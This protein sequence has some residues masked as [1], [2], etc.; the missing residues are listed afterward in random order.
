MNLVQE[1]TGNALLMI[2]KLEIHQ[3]Q[4]MVFIMSPQKYVLMKLYQKMAVVL[5]YKTMI[6]HAEKMKAKEGEAGAAHVKL[7]AAPKGEGAAMARVRCPFGEIYQ[8]MD[9]KHK[10]M[11]SHPGDSEFHREA[12]EHPE[13]KSRPSAAN[14]PATQ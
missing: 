3:M 7:T 8:R 6:R 12:G 5:V 4:E 10:D 1:F 11:Y 9:M 14:Q 13:E 2:K